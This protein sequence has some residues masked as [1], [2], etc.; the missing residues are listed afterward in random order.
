MNGVDG[1][2]SR[3]WTKTGAADRGGMSARPAAFSEGFAPVYRPN[4]KV[5]ILGSL[6]GLMSLERQQYYAQPR[7]AFWDIMGELF[8][9]GRELAYAPRLRRLTAHAVALWDVLAAGRRPGSL[10]SAIDRATA[11][12][13][14]FGAFFDSHGSVG[15]ICFNGR[16]AADLYHRRILPEL[17]AELAV[18]P[19][20]VLPSTS[21]AYAAMPFERKLAAWAEALKDYCK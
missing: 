8:G 19:S 16:T 15:L 13:N 6:P 14:D 1:T 21:P 2:S 20:V 12:V 17:T 7:N 18:I 10:D 5:L 11:V 9:A 4:S 3:D